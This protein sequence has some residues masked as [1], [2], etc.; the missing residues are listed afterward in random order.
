MYS[1]CPLAI[2]WGMPMKD[3]IIFL[4]Q[5]RIRVLN[6]RLPLVKNKKYFA[7]VDFVQATADS[8]NIGSCSLHEHYW[9]AGHRTCDHKKAPV[10][11]LY[12][13]KTKQFVTCKIEYASVRVSTVYTNI[14]MKQNT[15]SKI[16]QKYLEWSGSV[17]RR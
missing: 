3:L 11:L 7:F 4:R 12:Q 9:T 16:R 10:M 13:E 5:T 2:I 17:Q 6:Y 15:E 1:Y 8:F 14:C